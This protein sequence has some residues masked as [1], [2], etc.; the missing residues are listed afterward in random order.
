MPVVFFVDP[1]I[2][3]GPGHQ[4][5]RRDHPELYILPGGNRHR[6]PLEAEQSQRGKRHEMAATKNHDYHL[7]EPDPWPL[8][9]AICGGVLFS[10]LGHVVPR[11][12][13]RRAGH[14]RSASPA[15]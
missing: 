14:A 10:G 15:C 4:G 6:G 12:P 5:H 7:V 1:K 11:Q 8:I 13:L 9:G 2:K 3:Q